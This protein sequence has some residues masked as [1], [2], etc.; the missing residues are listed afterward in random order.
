MTIS[1]HL[2]VLEASGLVRLAQTQPEIEYLFRHALVQEAAYASLVK[3]DRRQLHLA[4]GEALEQLYPD[5]LQSRELAPLLAEHF[6]KAGDD[7]HALKYFTLAGDA[8]AR[9]YANTEAI[10]HYTRALE[11]AKR[12]PSPAPVREAQGGEASET[13]AS[14]LHLY[15]SLGTALELNGQNVEALAGYNAMEA[16]ARSRGD[17]ALEF[18]ALMARAKLYSVPNPVYDPAQAQTLLEQALGLARARGDRVNEARVLW[19][20]MLLNIF[21]SADMPQAV[22]YGEQ[23]LALARELGL[24]EQLAFTLNDIQYA[25]Q[26]VGQPE[27]AIAVQDEARELWRE[28]GNLPMLADNLSNTSVRYISTGQY[29]RAIVTAAEAFQIAQ[30]IGNVWGQAN[31]QFLLGHAYLERGLI[32]EAVEVMEGAVRLGEQVTHPPALI[33]AQA[34]LGWTYGTLGAV[35]RGIE[36]ARRGAVAAAAHFRLWRPWAM[37]AL[38]RLHLLKGDLAAAEAAIE[39]GRPDLK[40]GSL[41]FYSPV[42]MAFAEGELALARGDYERTL[43]VIDDALAHMRQTELRLYISDALHLKGQ[44]FRAQNRMDEARAALGQAR[45]EAEAMRSRRSLWPI[46]TTLSEI[47]GNPA[48]AEALRQKAKEITAF[49]ADHAPPD[50]RASFLNLPRVRAVLH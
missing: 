31:S 30:S 29:E 5:Q 21:D 11:I 14:L 50:L 9:V 6:S 40:P 46:L 23:S 2:T 28:L 17:R 13:S 38:A 42:L 25:Y 20:L 32:A 33:A 27:R 22:V 10:W 18:A 39:D 7:E 49:I 47:E 48:E 26:I 34:D 36:L 43:T 16:E 24:R 3:A 35:E 1:A 41:E 45:E 4:V 15:T 8:A 12:A 37:G 44:A 19:N